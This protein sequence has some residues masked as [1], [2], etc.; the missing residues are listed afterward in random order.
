MSQQQILGLSK[1]TDSF[2]VLGDFRHV[3]FGFQKPFKWCLNLRAKLRMK[4]GLNTAQYEGKNPIDLA[5]YPTQ[6]NQF[7]KA[8]EKA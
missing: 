4:F 5:D 7:R 8:R 1:E 2:N 3:S 6:R